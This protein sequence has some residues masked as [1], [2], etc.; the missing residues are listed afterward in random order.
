M[1]DGDEM[2]LINF[3]LAY[4]KL[5]DAIIRLTGL[6]EGD[7]VSIDVK[8]AALELINRSL[9]TDDLFEALLL[10]AVGK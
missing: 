1:K 6:L 4:T 5:N 8:M 7:G 9:K 10:E 3:G 2:T